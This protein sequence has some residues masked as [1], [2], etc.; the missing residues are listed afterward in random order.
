MKML[1]VIILEVQTLHPS[2]CT[3]VIV[4][5]QIFVFPQKKKNWYLYGYVTNQLSCH[6]P[7]FPT[8]GHF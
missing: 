7:K 6:F 3:T 8:P 1:Y 4:L 5:N 2:K